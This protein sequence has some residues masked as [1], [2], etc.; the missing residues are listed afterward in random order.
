MH[1]H[2]ENRFFHG[3]CGTTATCPSIFLL[4]TGDCNL[5]CIPPLRCGKVIIPALRAVCGGSVRCVL[6]E[7]GSRAAALGGRSRASP[8]AW[9]QAAKAPAWLAHSK[10]VCPPCM[11]LST[12]LI[13][14]LSATEIT[15]P[16][17]CSHCRNL[18]QRPTP[19]LNDSTRRL[20]VWRGSEG[21]SSHLK[22]PGREFGCILPSCGPARRCRICTC[23]HSMPRRWR[24]T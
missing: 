8:P 1:G 3:Y 2:Q 6:L 23:W 21:W 13:V 4:D 19:R 24:R 18:L 17:P 20:S 11:L 7:C 9:Q 22:E 5:L 15:D 12:G 10:S 16:A 14:N